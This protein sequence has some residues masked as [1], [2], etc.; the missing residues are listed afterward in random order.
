MIYM[1]TV[2]LMLVGAAA[3]AIMVI[4]IW[5]VGAPVLRRWRRRW[6]TSSHRKDR[7][8]RMQKQGR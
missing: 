3:C 2:I 6:R 7:A 8:L 4:A 1:L 5:D